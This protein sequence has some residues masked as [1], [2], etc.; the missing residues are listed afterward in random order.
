MDIPDSARH[1]LTDISDLRTKICGM[2]RKTDMVIT[3][4]TIFICRNFGNLYVIRLT[5]RA[6]IMCFINF[7]MT[8]Y[9]KVLC[10]LFI[11]F[12]QCMPLFSAVC[13][14]LLRITRSSITL[15]FLY[16]RFERHLKKVPVRRTDAY[17][18]N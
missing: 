2:Q 1:A 7:V 9:C 15:S 10:E 13:V 16:P 11:N 6:Y 17:S 18:Q 8:F 3:I 4:F 12:L 14:S 5:L